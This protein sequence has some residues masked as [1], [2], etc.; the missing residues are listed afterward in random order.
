MVRRVIHIV[1]CLAVASVVCA[2]AAV[3]ADE[4]ENAFNELY[5]EQF[6]RVQ[7]TRDTADDVELANKLLSAARS[8]TDTPALLAVLCERIWELCARDAEALPAMRQSASL[9]AKAAP[10]AMA[11]TRQKLLDSY[12]KLYAICRPNQR[13]DVGEQYMEV[14]RDDAQA[15][16]GAGDLSGAI[17]ATRKAVG[18]ATAIRSTA[19]DELR[20]ELT[21][22]IARQKVVA[23]VKQLAAALKSKPQ[24]K[25]AREKLVSLYVIDLDSPTGALEFLNE[26]LT[27]TWRTYVPL[28][29]KKVES[30]D[31]AVLLELAAWYEGHARGS[32]AAPVAMLL[33]ARG[34]YEQYLRKHAAADLSAKKAELALK[35]LSERLAKLAP[36][37]GFA[38]PVFADK[39]IGDVFDRAVEYL[40]SAQRDDGHWRCEEHQGYPVGPTALITLALLESGASAR[41]PRMEKALKWLAEHKTQKTY[42]LGLRC[43]VWQLASR[44]S[45]ANLQALLKN[46]VELLLK[47]ASNGSYDYDCRGQPNRQPGNDNSTSQYGL[48]GVH[49]GAKAKLPINKAY[50]EMARKYWVGRQNQDGSW[51]YRQGEGRGALTV[52]GIYSLMTCA[53]QLGKGP[54]AAGAPEIRRAAAWLEKNHDR[55]LRNR[56]QHPFYYLYGLGRMAEVGG[57]TKFGKLDW[58]SSGAEFL[59]KSQNRNGY[60]IGDYGPDVST[61]FAV[62]F[63]AKGSR[64]QS[65]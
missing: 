17:E 53:Q 50:W 5:G 18:V 64:V 42:A 12:Q 6:R 39:A 24:D 34:Y 58:F 47:S 29:A 20:Q 13:A 63:L 11:S 60:W 23:Q 10:K 37:M 14:L 48:L 30:L 33:R 38:R 56:G 41:E 55:T 8:S 44:T 49:A 59:R 31:E 65:R 21:D 62:L 36:A 45:S 40:W 3:R 35:D 19:K 27:E 15:R 7:L 46:D 2:P 25:A 32:A 26:D 54:A 1:V 51:P 16:A 22:L 52:A 9:L 57:P 43:S 28:A 4:A 61:A